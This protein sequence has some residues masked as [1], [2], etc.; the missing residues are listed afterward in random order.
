MNN[1]PNYDA[2][3]PLQSICDFIVF[4][5]IC[6]SGKSSTAKHIVDA[7]CSQID[8][9]YNHGSFSY[10]EQGRFLKKIGD[11]L[12]QNMA[13]PLYVTDLTIQTIQHIRPA[14]E[15]GKAV[16]QDRYTD[17][18]ISYS[19]AVTRTD[20]SPLFDIARLVRT[21]EDHH[22]FIR[23]KVCVYFF[24]DRDILLHRMSRMITPIHLKYL[25]NPDLIDIVKQEFE[26]LMVYREQNGTRVIWIDSGKVSFE[27]VISQ[28][29]QE[30]FVP[31]ERK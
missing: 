31:A 30:L 27:N 7:M 8:I 4:E 10:T 14:L 24:A 25:Q 11:E 19:S 16:I 13:D 15:Q 6:K 2:G 21:Y 1:H 12:P 22:I 5:G 23:P 29:L 28:L 26:R 9:T 20:N 17:S 3:Q 18:I